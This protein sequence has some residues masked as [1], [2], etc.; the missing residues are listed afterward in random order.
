M[1]N[2]VICKGPLPENMEK[3]YTAKC[4][5]CGAVN[6]LAT[7]QECELFTAQEGYLQTRSNDYLA[8]MYNLAKPYIF[9]IILKQ[10]RGKKRYT[11][12]YLNQKVEEAGQDFVLQYLTTPDFRIET[13]FGKYFRFKVLFVLFNRKQKMYEK[14]ECFF[15]EFS[16]DDIELESRSSALDPVEKIYYVRNKNSFYPVEIGDKRILED[17]LDM[18]WIHRKWDRPVTQIIYALHYL[19]NFVLPKKPQRAVRRFLDSLDISYREACEEIINLL[20]IFALR[21]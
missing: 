15:S 21:V 18:I 4:P 9:N 3:N 16:K 7:R 14:K 13:S 11:D 2:C 5:S 19:F 20:A 6:P 12:E 1:P 10:L 8:K 17:F